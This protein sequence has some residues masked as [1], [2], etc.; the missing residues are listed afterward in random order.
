M[1]PTTDDGV[2]RFYDSLAADY[3][4]MA[5]W[6]ERFDRERP[7]FSRLIAEREIH[8]A[9]DAGAGTGFHSILLGTLGVRVT[10]VDVSG[11]MLSVLGDR[12]S[13]LGLSVA[14]VEGSL[15]ALGSVAPAP[16]DAVVCMGNTVAHLLRSEEQER[17]ASECASAIRPGGTLVLQLL[18]Y[19]RIL[20]RRERIQNVRE[21]GGMIFIR[22]YDFLDDGIHFN[23]LRLE[24]KASGFG[25][26]LTTVR[27][28]PIRR[29]AIVSLLE[30]AG[31]SSVE[32][33]GGLAELPFDPLTSQ[34]CLVVARRA[35]RG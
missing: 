6:E 29:D 33:Y 22:F 35:G 20:A 23:I 30:R 1:D 24:P 10:A 17:F 28:N 14:T 2:R 8:T 12:V 4:R 32:T 26:T 31:F 11:A 34:D 18:N 3:D 21:R 19:D 25:H 9:I 7:F 5:G 13:A 27:L 15:L 16:V